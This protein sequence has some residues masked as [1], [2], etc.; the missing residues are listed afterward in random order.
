MKCQ[1]LADGRHPGYTLPP[2]PVYS[3]R[4][5]EQD[6][7]SRPEE[8]L[9]FSAPSLC[10]CSPPAFLKLKAGRDYGQMVLGPAYQKLLGYFPEAS[11]SG[12]AVHSGRIKFSWGGIQESG[13]SNSVRSDEADAPQEVLKAGVWAEAVESWSSL[14]VSHHAV[15]LPICLFQPLKGLVIFSEPGIDYRYGVR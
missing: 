10:N 13:R 7:S 5:P 4:K 6:G 2:F 14:Q 11:R 12:L 3:C 1:Y 15:T 9:T 8:S